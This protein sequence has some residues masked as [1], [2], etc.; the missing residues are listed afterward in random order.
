MQGAPSGVKGDGVQE[1]HK[2]AH[3]VQA[4]AGDEDEEEEEEEV[5]EWRKRMRPEVVIL[6]PGPS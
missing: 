6:V 4:S 5:V 1:V 3:H 2:A